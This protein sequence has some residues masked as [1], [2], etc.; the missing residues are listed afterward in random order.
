LAHALRLLQNDRTPAGYRSAISRAYYAAFHSAREFIQGMLAVPLTEGPA[1]HGQVRNHLVSTGA[2][3]IDQVSLDL[4]NLHS[5]RIAAD[6]RLMKRH[7]EKEQLAADLVNLAGDI[8][9]TM[10]RCRSDTQRYAIVR[11]AV[12]MRS[13]QLRGK[14]P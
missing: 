9:A 1:A 6:Y 11:D 5:E 8:I 3:E 10:N 14:A 2:E 12:R 7:V 13:N 4:A